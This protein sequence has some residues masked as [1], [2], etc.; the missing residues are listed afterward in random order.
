MLT[1]VE[2]NA[3]VEGSLT[4]ILLSNKPSLDYIEKLS[5][6][7]VF[8]DGRLS[9]IGKNTSV[10]LMPLI[11]ANWREHFKWRGKGPITNDELTALEE[12]ILKVYYEGKKY[13]SGDLQTT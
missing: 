4:I 8:L 7:Y 1:Y 13:D 2:E 9:D 3:V 10:N 5:P 6:R 12:I 11:S